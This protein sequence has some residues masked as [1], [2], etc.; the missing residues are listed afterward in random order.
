MEQ[1]VPEKLV[2]IMTDAVAYPRAMVVHPHHTGL[3]DRTVMGSGRTERVALEAILP[4]TE[5]ASKVVLLL[6]NQLLEVQPLIICHV[7]DL[8]LLPG[9]LLEIQEVHVVGEPFRLLI[10]LQELWGFNLLNR[11]LLPG[12]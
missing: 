2:V 12:V 11:L 9:H 6:V 3:A 8:E 10:G 7:V 1:E 5:P 4:D